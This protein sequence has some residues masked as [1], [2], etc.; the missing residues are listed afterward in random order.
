MPRKAIHLEFS[1]IIMTSYTRSND[2]RLEITSITLREDA[3][4]QLKNWLSDTNIYIDLITTESEKTVRDILTSGGLSEEQVKKIFVTHASTDLELLNAQTISESLN[5]NVLQD[6]TEHLFYGE[7]ENACRAVLALESQC[8]AV[9]KK[10]CVYKLNPNGNHFL[11]GALRKFNKPADS[12][13]HPYDLAFI[14]AKEGKAETL[15]FLFEK[16][17]GMDIDYPNWERKN[18]LT[19]ALYYGHTPL[20][21]LLLTKFKADITQV[22]IPS[23]VDNQIEYENAEN[24][25]NFLLAKAKI[26]INQ[27]EPLE[28]Q[29]ALHKAAMYANMPLIQSLVVSFGAKINQLNYNMNPPLYYLLTFKAFE[30][31]KGDIKAAKFLLQHLAQHDLLDSLTE[32]STSLTK[33]PQTLNGIE[34]IQ[35]EAF[36]NYKRKIFEYLA[37]LIEVNNCIKAAKDT[38]VDTNTNHFQEQIE[39]WDATFEQIQNRWENNIQ[40]SNETYARE[41]YNLSNAIKSTKNTYMQPLPPLTPIPV[42]LHQTPSAPQPGIPPQIPSSA[43]NQRQE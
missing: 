19:I 25:I 37:Y 33:D 16:F 8:S 10:L 6:V 40:F 31:C 28:G 1:S 34:N 3:H 26:T 20:A 41:L 29:T 27:P 23:F 11:E 24:A 7:D 38:G 42:V 39:K 35:S 18:L 21:N 17:P 14:T 2:D 32:L 13:G 15:A 5:K 9:N 4:I 43:P 30:H 22:F 36:F 12:L